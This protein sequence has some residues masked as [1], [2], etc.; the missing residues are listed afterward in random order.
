M[1]EEGWTGKE[2]SVAAMSKSRLCGWKHNAQGL[3]SKDSSLSK[4]CVNCRKA[5]AAQAGGFE[6]WGR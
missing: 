5:M 3:G 2:G 6:P 4:S 1:I